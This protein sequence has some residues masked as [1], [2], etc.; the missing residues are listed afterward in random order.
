MKT[1]IISALVGLVLLAATFMLYNTVFFTIIIDIVSL[2]AV[3]E[4]LRCMGLSKDKT[5]AVPS[6]VF[7]AF[8][9][10]LSFEF[11]RNIF[12]ALSYIY[13]VYLF[14]MLLIKHK[15]LKISDITKCFFI[16]LCYPLSF[17]CFI[18]L[19][20]ANPKEGLFYILLVFIAAWLS[21]TGA[22][23]V[24]SFFGKH[25]LCPEISP[26]KTVEG[27]IG[28]LLSAV[29]GYIILAVI[30]SAI[31]KDAITINYLIIIIIAPFASVAGMVGDLA[32]SVIKRQYNIKDY[33]NIMPGHGGVM[34]RFDSV[35][36]VLP[37]IYVI[38]GFADLIKII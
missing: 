7:A 4:L 36:F 38:T 37:L 8:I 15:T 3:Y 29:I 13:L 17:S 23:F 24:G 16:C 35:L 6:I 18:F 21:D 28:G 11:I 26:K 19:K 25:K 34:D 12:P 30:Y 27:A 31:Y 1:R 32:A 33:G 2:I 9:P 20:D 22:Y 10:F 14:V 5:L